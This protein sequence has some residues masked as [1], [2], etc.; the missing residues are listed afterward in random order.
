MSTVTTQI[1][2]HVLTISLNRAD[3]KNALTREMYQ[4]IPRASIRK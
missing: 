2:N 3:K 4:L 1:E